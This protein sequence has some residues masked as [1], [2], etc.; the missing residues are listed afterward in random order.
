MFVCIS[1]LF[2]IIIF[3]IKT[4]IGQFC[5]II[6]EIMSFDQIVCLY[7]VSDQ[8]VCLCVCRLV[9]CCC[10]CSTSAVKTSKR[11]ARIPLAP[12][13]NMCLLNVL[14]V[15][16]L[17]HM[18]LVVYVFVCHCCYLCYCAPLQH[19]P[20]STLPGRRVSRPRGRR[21]GR[22]R[23]PNNNNNNINNMVIIIII[24]K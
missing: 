3:G 5:I 21:R 6:Y 7:V 4:I 14:P 2:G 22:S 1:F 19:A 17:I 8:I 13:C 11:G 18:S 20:L 23:S 16:W 15:D 10:M 12:L 9:R 24:I